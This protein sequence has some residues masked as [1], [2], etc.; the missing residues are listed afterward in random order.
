[1]FRNTLLL[2]ALLSISLCSMAQSD[3]DKKSAK[4]VLQELPDM[5][6]AQP[7]AGPDTNANKLI[8]ANISVVINPMWREKGVLNFVDFKLPKTDKEPLSTTFPQPVR[9]QNLSVTMSTIKKTPEE[10]FALVQ[11]SVKAHLAAYYKSN[12]G[13]LKNEE[14]TEKLNAMTS[15][16]EKFTCDNGLTGDL[17]TMQDVED[18]Q[19]NYIILLV[20]PSAKAGSTDFVQ[21]TYTRYIYE[22]DFPEDIMELKAF[23]YPDEQTEYLNF[24]KRILKTLVIK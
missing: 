5:L 9:I 11:N 8:S 24:T 6:I 21:F 10:K 7:D 20:L 3:K 16:P 19:S 13:A 17:Y 18:N 15:G 14:L 23:E 22:T 2:T 12:F 1:M 4:E